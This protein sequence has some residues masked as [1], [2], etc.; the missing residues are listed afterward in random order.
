[1]DSLKQM[2]DKD[3]FGYVFKFTYTDRPLSVFLSVSI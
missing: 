1:M 2:F 3:S